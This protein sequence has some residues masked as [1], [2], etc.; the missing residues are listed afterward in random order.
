MQAFFLSGRVILD[1]S[2]TICYHLPMMRFEFLEFSTQRHI[3]P[4]HDVLPL[5]MTNEPNP[6]SPK[7]ALVLQK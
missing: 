5:S 1:K 7:T 4:R 3:R 6:N 2:L